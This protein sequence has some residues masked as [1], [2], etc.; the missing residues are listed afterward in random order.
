MMKFFIS[1]ATGKKVNIEQVNSSEMSFSLCVN[2]VSYVLWSTIQPLLLS[3]FSWLSLSRH[4][5]RKYMSEWS[6]CWYLGINQSSSHD[7]AL[8][9]LLT[10]I[11][12]KPGK[13]QVREWEMKKKNSLIWSNTPWRS[14]MF[15]L[16]WFFAFLLMEHSALHPWIFGIL[17][18]DISRYT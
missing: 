16:K 15:P 4:S 14:L 7:D 1:L 12:R 18:L 8:H 17:P 9:I 5:N 10:T 3:S 2:H 6:N 13:L 11:K